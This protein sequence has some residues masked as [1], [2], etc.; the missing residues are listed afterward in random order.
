M[1]AP[2]GGTVR[3]RTWHIDKKIHLKKIFS[4]SLF[5]TEPQYQSPLGTC[6]NYS[7]LVANEKLLRY[8]TRKT[9]HTS[10]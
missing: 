3:G 4:C 9:G 8:F 5:K 1:E 6:E 2:T 10:L 7:N